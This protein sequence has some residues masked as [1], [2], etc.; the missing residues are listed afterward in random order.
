[1][2]NE[3]LLVR[4]L[5]LADS[6]LGFDLPVRPRT[7]RRR[8]GHDLRANYEAAL[9]PAREGSVDL[10]VHGGDL[11]HR[12]RVPRSLAYDALRPLAE[13]AEAGVPV[14]VVPG[15]HEGSR[16]PHERFG[17]HSNLHIFRGPGTFLVNVRGC[18]VAVAGFPYVRHRIRERFPQVLEETGW[19]QAE[20]DLR[21]LCF[22]HCV[23]GATVGPG[24]YTFRYAADVIRSADLPAGCAA[25]LS[26]HIHRHQV[27]RR[28]LQG[29][30]L[31]TPVLYPGSVER[32]SFAEMGEEKGYLLLELEPT[33]GGRELVRH[34]FVPLPTRPMLVRELH[35]TGIPGAGWSS[36]E[37]DA[38]L[39]AALA[40]VP[41]DAVLR[42]RIHGG[43]PLEARSSLGATHLRRL[44]PPQMNLEV[45]LVDERAHRRS[46]TPGIHRQPGL[47]LLSDPEYPLAGRPQVER[48]RLGGLPEARHPQAGGRPQARRASPECLPEAGQISSGSQLS[49]DLPEVERPACG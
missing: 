15:N 48:P 41:P 29:R 28:D 7:Q 1:M 36:H 44:T 12:S 20:A 14:F 40:D 45:V 23:E 13:V 43:V 2:P 21:L 47:G 46:R 16:I 8:R 38:R 10:V 33:P 27:L 30:S 37:L 11:F 34:R 3:N 31:P 17:E 22:H 9:E 19:R 42:I 4:I 5:L 25:V 26:G 32:T 39:A 24:D 6:H 35:P 18:R 49:L